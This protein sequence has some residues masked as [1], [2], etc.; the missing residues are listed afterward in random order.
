[1]TEET[2][3]KSDVSGLSLILEEWKVVVETQ[4]H[5]NQMLMQMRQQQLVLF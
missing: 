3:K 1:M 5:F 4:M 2:T